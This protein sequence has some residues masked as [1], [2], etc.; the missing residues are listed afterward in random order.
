MSFQEK[1]KVLQK[2][3]LE[4]L[5]QR[6]T[7]NMN[8]E[9]GVAHLSPD[10]EDRVNPSVTVTSQ[11]IKQRTGRDKIRNVVIDEYQKALTMPGIVVERKDNDLTVIVLPTRK[12]SNDYK[13]LSELAKKNNSEIAE[14]PDLAEP[15]F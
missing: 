6:L 4:L 2:E 5:T 14:D 10:H 8:K 7:I 15:Y 12:S 9:T 1:D 13:S 3:I 11:E